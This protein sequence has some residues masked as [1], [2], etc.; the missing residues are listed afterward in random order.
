MLSLRMI[1]RI[2][3][4]CIRSTQH[5]AQVYVPYDLIVNIWFSKTDERPQS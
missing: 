1:T 3:A 4:D 5:P 2:H